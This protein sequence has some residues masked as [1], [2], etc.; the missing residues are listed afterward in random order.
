MKRRREAEKASEIRSAIEELSVVVKI[1]PADGHDAAHIHHDDAAQIHHDA[2]Q[3]P[4][5]TFLS[6][7]N[8]VVQILDKIGPTMAVLRQDVHQNI[9]RLEMLHQSEPSRYSNLVEIVKKE[10][11]EGIAREG[12]S[13]S[14]AFVWL[15]R[16]L[17]F[18]VALLQKLAND[19][20][21]SMEQAVEE[22]Y[23][24]TL[25]PWHRW[26]S[27]AACKVAL[28]IVPDNKTFINLLMAKD[29]DYD[30]LKEDIQTLISLLVP[31][32]EEIHSILG[33]YG[34]D[35]LKSN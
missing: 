35:R 20:G 10:V 11:G 16:S 7:C 25:K 33:S 8:L 32:L 9:Q 30:T 21:K 27:S 14:R 19:P 15:T 1:K 12:K 34:L 29:E 17:D 2:A 18:T 26:I 23:D 13:C 6:V 5:K 31:L 24:I 22:S 28:K 4:T 3:I